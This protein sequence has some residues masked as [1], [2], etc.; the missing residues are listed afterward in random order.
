[1]NNSYIKHNSN[2]QLY[3]ANS[4]EE[5]ANESNEVF[6]LTQYRSTDF[7]TLSQNNS[8]YQNSNI[9]NLN[10]RKW[11]VDEVKL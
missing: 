7:S 4:L 8:E 2:K 5:R 9:Q 3:E 6:E 11:T 10:K 1:M